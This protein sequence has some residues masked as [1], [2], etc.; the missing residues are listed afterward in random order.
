[1]SKLTDQAKTQFGIPDF[2][3]AAR[4]ILAGMGIELWADID[5]VAA[6]LGRDFPW[7]D[8]DTLHVAE[9]SAWVTCVIRAAA[10]APNEAIPKDVDR[11]ELVLSTL[12]EYLVHSAFHLD[13]H[14]LFRLWPTLCHALLDTEF[15]T[16]TDLFRLPFRSFYLQWPREIGERIAL[17]HQ[18]GTSFPSDGA[19]VTTFESPEDGQAIVVRIVSRDRYNARPDRGTSHNYHQY[20]IAPGRCGETLDED[21]IRKMNPI[22]EAGTNFGKDGLRLAFNAILYIASG[23]ADLKHRESERDRLL[24]DFSHHPKPTQAERRAHAL[25]RASHVRIHDAGY[26]I[27]IPH[28]PSV[29]VGATGASWRLGHRVAVRGHW[30]NQVVGEG[31]TGRKLMWIQPHYRGPEIAEVVQRAYDVGAGHGVA[32]SGNPVTTP[33]PPEEA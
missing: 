4:D 9:S 15:R 23:G 19:F 30:R 16:P 31:R 3:A 22:G 11:P 5:R 7:S 24:R 2:Q 18:D 27:R 28:S 25:A 26:S 33:N 20:R 8:G 21:T 32:D 1:M 29:G 14:H 17:D 13:G 12:R 10:V 6:K